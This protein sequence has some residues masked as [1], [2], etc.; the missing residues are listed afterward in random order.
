MKFEAALIHEVLNFHF[1]RMI[2]TFKVKLGILLDF[3]RQLI[4]RSLPLAVSVTAILMFI[5]ERCL[6]SLLVE[7]V[8]LL[9]INKCV[10]L[11]FKV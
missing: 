9:N 6:I 1:S 10:L 2:I 5:F 8:L 11:A 3:Q 7:K 4:A